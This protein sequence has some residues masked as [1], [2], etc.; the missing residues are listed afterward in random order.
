MLALRH[1]ATEVVSCTEPMLWRDHALDLLQQGEWSG[2]DGERRQGRCPRCG[3]KLCAETALACKQSAESLC[4]RRSITR[5]SMR[6]SSR[7]KPRRRPTC[8]TM[9]EWTTW[10]CISG[11]W[12]SLLLQER[13]CIGE[14]MRIKH[15]TILY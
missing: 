6:A 1:G 5:T 12:L 3:H 8:R 13:A 9:R 10:R 15:G 4:M 7:C 2:R 14:L 11:R